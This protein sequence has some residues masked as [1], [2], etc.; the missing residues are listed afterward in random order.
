[1]TYLA[2]QNYY[3]V[4]EVS[5]QAPQ[6]EIRRAYDRAKATYSQ[7]NEALYSVFSKEEARE[8]LKLIEEAY[9]VLGNHDL[10]RAYDEKLRGRGM[11][12]VPDVS[13]GEMSVEPF[14]EVVTTTQIDERYAIPNVAVGQ[15]TAVQNF[16]YETNHIKDESK[17]NVKLAENSPESD[18]K[19]GKTILSQYE[20]N[21]S[22][23]NIITTQEIYDGPFLKRIREYKNVPLDQLSEHIRV[24]K[25][26]LDAL[27]KNDFDR[28]P[29]PVFVRG[30]VVQYAKIMKLNEHR[31]AKS[32]MD[33]MKK[34]IGS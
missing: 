1:M 16:A 22:F 27:E 17:P 23:E 7:D 12:I 29:A 4:L 5:P 25:N 18:L 21:E 33:L 31:V 32:Y 19:I 10:R 6:N 13:Q 20:I 15:S 11:T 14:R 28:L 34:T 9:T 30:F 24:G 8:L 2:E 26:Y 3:E